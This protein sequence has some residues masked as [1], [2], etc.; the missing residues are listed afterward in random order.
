M[1]KYIEKI[2]LLCADIENELSIYHDYV[3]DDL[4][5]K[6]NTLLILAD[7]GPKLCQTA[8]KVQLEEI[9][10]RVNIT[11]YAKVWMYSARIQLEP[12]AGLLKELLEYIISE[13][14]F[15]VN[16]KFFLYYQTIWVSQVYSGVNH[17]DI[18]CL[19]WKLYNQVL[20][21]FKSK[22]EDLLEPVPEE[23]R[24]E[25]MALV[26]T[27]QMSGPGHAP[28]RRTLDR[29][30]MLIKMNKK[31]FLINT[32]E[33][34]S[35]VG[36]IPYYGSK[37]GVYNSDLLKYEKI[38]WKDVSFSFF[39]AEKNMP[40]MAGL[41]LLLEM[42]QKIKPGIVISVGASIL[43]DLVNDIMPVLTIGL[44]ASRIA[45]TNTACQTLSRELQAADLQL[46]NKFG[47]N[48]NN[49]IRS[50]SNF[51]MP[52]QLESVTREQ[53]GLPEDKFILAIS[54]DRL[55]EELDKKF[56]DM[57]CQ[58]VDDD[59]VIVLLGD[60]D[61]SE[62]RIGQPQEL[63]NKIYSLGWVTD[64][65]SRIE[66]C[67]LYVNPCRR[68]AGTMSVMALVKGKP[69]VTVPYGDAAVNVGEDFWTES[70][71]TMPDLIR[72]YKNDADFYHSMS[73]KAK[74]RAAVLLDAEN[75]FRNVLREFKK[76]TN[77][78]QDVPYSKGALHD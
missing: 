5:N 66:L 65:L 36:S 29:C 40:N 54:G 24:D 6:T 39:Q 21:G 49:I 43:A 10:A 9:M 77:S 37:E 51:T 4:I 69:V 32:A 26:I 56:V 22:L 45:Y 50:V 64:F 16:V 41:R 73:V 55:R 1:S 58:A 12:E 20:Q 33:F 42:I 44:S 48:Q 78:C 70:Y 74:E 38:E 27:G 25:N 67:D 62:H 3:S 35:S 46:L 28:T 15:S 8:I 53:I 13:Q 31:V 17:E 60:M 63:K 19:Q 14:E 68:G 59:M 23:E 30:E 2:G 47:L 72:R 18:M 52:D 11:R 7:I 75:E 71:E 34:L 76:R 61:I 57:L